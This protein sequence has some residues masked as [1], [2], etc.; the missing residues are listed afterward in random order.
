[1]RTSIPFAL[2]LS[3]ALMGC[4]EDS[5]SDGSG[6]DDPT[7]MEDEDGT[8]GSESD[9]DGDPIACV[10]DVDCPEGE[11][12]MGELCVVDASNGDGDGD[13][14][15]SGDGDGDGGD[16]DGDGDCGDGIVDLGE[17]C[18]HG[19]ANSDMDPDAC[20]PDCTLP[21]C[22]DGVV[23]GLEDCDDGVDNSDTV[24]GACTTTC[25]FA[26]P[27]DVYCTLSLGNCA[28]EYADDAE[29]QAAC[30][31]FDDSGTTGDDTG[32][33]LQCRVYHAGVAA[34][35]PG[36]HCPSAGE[37]TA[38]ACIDG[39]PPP[40]C[41]EYCQVITAN[42]DGGNAQ[43]A[44]MDGCIAYC[45]DYGLAA[46]DASDTTGNTIGCR[47]Y[48]A[49]VAAQ[50]PVVHCPHAGPS[51]G[52]TCGSWCDVYCDMS[53]NNC[54]GDYDDH[55]DCQA[56]CSTFDDSGSVGDASGN[57]VQCRIYH[58]V[59][60]EQDGPLHC[61]HAGPSGGD[62]CGTWC[63]VYCDA[64]ANTCPGEY[65]DDGEC[66]SACAGFDDSGRPGDIAGDTVQCRIY[67]LG[68]A[69]E[70]QDPGTHC[71]HAAEVP[72]GGCEFALPACAPD[73]FEPN[74]A[75]VAATP[76]VEDSYPGLNAC[77]DEDWYAID[78][79]AGTS[80][81]VEAL[82]MQAEGDVEFT[83][84]G[85][86]GVE[87]DP[88]DD[89]D[90]LYQVDVVEA[91]TI[92]VRARLISDAG[93]E[94]GA[95]YSLDL[96][97][98][99]F[100]MP[101]CDNYCQVVTDNCDG[102]DAQYADVD[103]CLAYCADYVIPVGDASDTAG[104]TIGCRTYHAGVA[105]QDPAVHCSHAGPSGGDTCGSWC[106]V[107]CDMSANNCPGDYDDRDAC[108]AYCSTFDDSGSVGDASG[109][110]VQCRMYHAVVAEQD[111]PL[112]C[113]H[114][115]PSGGDVCGTWCDVYCDASA[116]T[117]PGEY[118][119]DSECQSACAG[120]DDS[121]SP[122]DIA[123]DTVQCRIHHLGL[124]QESQDPGTHCPHAAEVPVGGCEAVPVCTPDRFEPNDMMVA[125]TTLVED[126]YPGLTACM[127][128]DWY[129]IDVPAGTS[130][131][132]E[133]LYMQA[134]GDVEFTFFGP[135]GVEFDPEDGG[136][137]L[138][139]VDVVEAETIYVRARLISD[140]GVEPGGAYSLDLTFIPFP[141]PACDWTSATPDFVEVAVKD[142]V[143]AD[144]LSLQAFTSDVPVFDYV[145][146]T[147]WY[148]YGAPVGPFS[149]TF[150][151]ESYATCAVC[152]AF[153]AGF[154]GVDC[155]GWY[156]ATAGTL[157]VTQNDNTVGGTLS[158]TLSDM[159]FV[160]MDPNTGDGVPD[161]TTWCF[162]DSSAFDV[163]I[164]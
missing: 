89:G 72:V 90:G 122:G 69:Q 40:T 34:Q 24:L 158:G 21:R 32:D 74:D 92:Y 75:M 78:V 139:Q 99:P 9:P 134:E 76:L 43:Y 142:W 45:A 97:F 121:G 1:M 12:C 125:A 53:A 44:D 51:G 141:M 37:L 112:H 149:H 130:L 100:P 25:A 66:Q 30:G 70:S 161:G 128:D 95:G 108:Q 102:A 10:D 58:A 140:A 83:F 52:D 155:A 150:D 101:T 160:E 68:V 5:S 42:C 164:Q 57:T 127:D 131:Y 38:G 162:D 77:M 106:D 20:R 156:L 133:A 147:L 126:S 27:C 85:P 93:V 138:Y 117:C 59:I 29:C 120:F 96:I 50:D 123:G 81:Y 61:P 65:A 49:E 14:T 73:R 115:G 137:G 55:Q 31:D 146:V 67:H 18:D 64:S 62:V 113:P 22:G 56:Y 35:D 60:A 114:A 84:F 145:D 132:V 136:G 33:T 91:E 13:A 16:G 104:N 8:G 119:D 26:I 103:A 63:D 98:V 143:D 111:G 124:A 107:Y 135:D 36:T 11:R 54:P 86:D 109:N 23:D 3:I 148:A 79:P 129:A 88:Y 144:T 15:S 157:D 116:S 159:E 82:Y 154:D 19:A 87:F 48:H 46:G 17:E 110:T 94:A 118:A 163:T 28:G 41:D 47:T 2:L 6:D 151:G 7:S 105:A 153:C 80:L 152:A 4:A 39:P 71:P